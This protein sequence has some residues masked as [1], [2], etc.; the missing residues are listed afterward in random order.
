MPQIK[1]G[2]LH[3]LKKE[4]GHLKLCNFHNS[5]IRCGVRSWILGSNLPCQPPFTCIVCNFREVPSG[6][7]STSS[8]NSKKL[9]IICIYSTNSVDIY[10]LI[11]LSCL[12]IS[13]KSFAKQSS[14]DY[15]MG[16]TDMA[17]VLQE[18]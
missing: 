10:Q 13:G 15:D 6:S 1:Q 17:P 5:D 2:T 11:W 7:M 8:K 4:T 9:H 12:S 3:V 16:A 18:N 14:M